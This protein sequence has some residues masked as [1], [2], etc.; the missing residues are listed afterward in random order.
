MMQK[1][2]SF[3]TPASLTGALRFYISATVI[4]MAGTPLDAAPVV[5]G[6]AVTISS[7]SDVMTAG[8][9]VYAFNESNPAAPVVVN[10]VSFTGGN[11]YTTLGSG[12]ISMTI[13][14]QLSNSIFGAPATNP[15]E[16]LS[17][18]YKSILTGGIWLN[19]TYAGGSVTLN[20]LTAGRSYAVQVWMN[21]S[22]ANASGPGGE[23]RGANNVAIDYNTT[24]ALGGLGQYSK[25]WFRATGTSQAFSIFSKA[26]YAQMNAIQLRD[27]TGIGWWTG[28]GGSTWNPSS[29]ANFTT[30]LAAAPLT[31]A[32]FDTLRTSLGTVIFGDTY[33]NNGAQLAVTQNTIT[34][35][36]GGVS[37]AAV[38][39]QNTA[40]LPYTVTSPDQAGISGSASVWVDGGGTVTLA[41]NH[42][43]TGGTSIRS[44]S[45]ILT[46]TPAPS[47]IANAGSL[48]FNSSSNQVCSEVISGT[49]TLTKTGT[50][51][52]TLTRTNTYTGTTT[53]NGGTLLITDITSPTGTGAVAVNPSGTLAGTGPVPGAV[54]VNSGGTI[55]PT[56][57]A[58]GTGAVS[59]SS[60]AKLGGVGRASGAV[61]ISSGATIAPGNSVGTLNTGALTL[62]G[63]YACEVSGATTDK[64]AVTGNLNLTGSTLA[65]TATGATGTLVIASYTGT[66]TGTFG[67]VTGLPAGYAVNYNSGAKQVELVFTD[68]FG[69][70]ATSKGLTT[71]NNGKGDNPDNDGLNNLG[72]FAFDDEPLSGF[73][74]GKI[75]SKIVTIGPDQ[76]LTLTLPA[77][78]T[79]TFT[80]AA[81]TMT[82]TADTVTYVIEG[83][84]TL[85]GFPVTVT[86]VTGADATTIQTGLSLPALNSGWTFH[87]FRLSPT[88]GSAAK[89]FIRAK[90]SS[91]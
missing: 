17:T 70:W 29:T 58:T 23:L 42:S 3:L 16:S 68:A 21:D 2:P 53:V 91:P 76:V 12:A 25:G 39:F 81:P 19:D 77:R 61:T 11:S 78:S 10:G 41:G 66:L 22:R 4:A 47:P 80:A 6:P 72:E 54:T 89:G 64:I 20:N 57:S 38:I 75:V 52:L 31:T 67:T 24:N 13:F 86:E 55:S 37:G 26:A 45:L 14:N 49:G 73:P 30:N 40:A 35:S 43:Y 90:V 88:V 33:S 15:F 46:G 5:F 82:A 28:T 63:T 32:T 34:L 44:G 18:A 51:T 85:S 8:S 56:D 71:G 74:S 83:S 36:A 9:P 27:V 69:A 62:A 59:V 87:T 50:G 1:N 79:A 7:D 84:A 48:T 65:I 60:G